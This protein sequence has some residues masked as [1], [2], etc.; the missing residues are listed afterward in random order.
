[1]QRNI[2]LLEPNYKN[3]YPPIGLMKISTYHKEV[4]DTV[5][6]Y[7][8]DLKAFGLKLK[9]AACLTKLKRRVKGYNWNGHT[10]AISSYLA[11][12][13]LVHLN[14]ILS[15]IQEEHKNKVTGILKE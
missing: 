4:G 7:K 5:S 15:S 1:M 12:K 14:N 11:T 6:F 13:R 3:K 2:L 9:L 10:Q 8:G